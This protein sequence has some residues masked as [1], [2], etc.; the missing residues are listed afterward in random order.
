MLKK[1]DLQDQ[2]K[3][4]AETLHAEFAQYCLHTSPEVLL[5]HIRAIL[6]AHAREVY[7]A[8]KEAKQ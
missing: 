1:P 2:Y 8:N 4:D 6:H 3:K 5:N 7:A